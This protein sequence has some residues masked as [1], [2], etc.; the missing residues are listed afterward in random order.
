MQLVA[1]LVLG[2]F[3]FVMPGNIWAASTDPQEEL[4]QRLKNTQSQ[5]YALLQ[6]ILHLDTDLQAL[7]AKRLALTNRYQTL[8]QELALAREK[9]KEL[10]QKLSA[11]RKNFNHSLKFFQKHMVAPYLMAAIL[12]Q[13][14][15]EFFIRWELLQQYVRFLLNQVHQHLSLY[16]E[17]QK[18]R[19]TIERQEKEVAEAALEVAKLEDKLEAMKIVRQK[20][21][22]KVKNQIA[23]YEQA[24]LALERSWQETLPTL[25]ALFQRFPQFPWEKLTPD[26]L[27]LNY[28]RGTVVAEFSQQKIN[29]VLLEGQDSL[30]HIKFILSPG[31]LNILGP[32]FLLQ[33]T[34]AITGAHNLIFIPQ[35]LEVSGVPLDRSVWDILLPQP[36]FNIEL[37]APAFEL[38]FSRLEIQ[39]GHIVLELSRI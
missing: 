20:A 31:S 2:F 33:G 28:D 29:K 36:V 37:P 8:T 7:A 13:N 1:T 38:K 18:I 14:W 4:K 30:Q 10:T 39:E 22:E 9:E 12:S 17:A 24:L 27:R 21:L 16:K 34:L 23:Q 19:E 11:S 26:K 6:E 5:E 32:G 3:L 25:M 35:T 15:G